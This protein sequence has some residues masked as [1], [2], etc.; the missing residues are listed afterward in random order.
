MCPMTGVNNDWCAQWQVCTMTGVHSYR[1]GQWQVCTMTVVHSYR[2]AQW[3]VWTMTGVHSDKCA[4]W[5]VCTVIDVPNDRCAQSQVCL[6]RRPGDIS[7][8]LPQSKLDGSLQCE[9]KWREIIKSKT[10]DPET[11]GCGHDSRHHHRAIPA[12]LRQ[13]A[14][15]YS[16]ISEL[17]YIIWHKIHPATTHLMM[18]IVPLIIFGRGTV[19]TTVCLSVSVFVCRLAG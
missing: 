16:G 10:Y 8:W 11:R 17:A 19:L 3:Q 14:H 15:L 4:Q 2:C 9:I 12:F 7:R 13:Y 6:Q 5:Q 18:K 1:C